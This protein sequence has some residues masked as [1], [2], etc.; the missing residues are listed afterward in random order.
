MSACCHSGGHQHSSPSGHFGSRFSPA[1]T[2]V[3]VLENFRARRS[4][5]HTA[6]AL[7][8]LPPPQVPPAVSAR[9]LMAW[10]ML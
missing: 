3:G 8:P 4:L 2:T 5:Q 10:K 6:N 1:S 7:L 9:V